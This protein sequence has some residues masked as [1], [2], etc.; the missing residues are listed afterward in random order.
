MQILQE[1]QNQSV[2][3]KP[4]KPK[5][6]WVVHE[7][8]AVANALGYN[9]HNKNMREYSKPYLDFDN[10]ARVA[11]SIVPADH[12]IP[13]YGKFNIM[14]SMFES[15]SL[16]DS[17]V[18]SMGKCDA[19]IVPC[20]FC[21]EIFRKYTSLPIHVCW[22]GV[23]PKKYPYHERSF[24]NLSK[25][26]KFRFL[27]LGAP[28]PRK[29]YPL[30][31]ELVKLV[32]KV[33]EWEL[34]IKTTLPKTSYLSLCKTIWRRRKEI[35]RGKYGEDERKAAFRMMKNLARVDMRK[36][37]RVMG[38]HKNIIFDARYLDFDEL[39]NL[40]HSAH[41][42]VLPSSGEG[43]GLTLCE[44]MATGA[45]CIA[46]EHTGMAEF[47]DERV[48]YTIGYTTVEQ[49]LK[50]YALT[51]QVYL[52]NVEDIVKRMIQIYRNYPEALC[53]GKRASERIHTKFTWDKSAQRLR[54]IIELYS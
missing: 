26:E 45:P 24:P 51:T 5:V 30:I 20:R 22:E 52:C 27:W 19:I 46:P 16:P 14:F 12:F 6:C 13:V 53:R 11:L 50:N 43:W 28:N 41:T 49:R 39:M 44:A 33:P 9:T 48:G 17:Y 15:L 2:V 42:F 8:T 54:D 29:G 34:Y 3:I 38:K 35:F 25:G 7:N 31:Q 32:E 47:F 18:T 40:Y 23:E 4:V 21:K 1:T 10:E 37:Y 36:P